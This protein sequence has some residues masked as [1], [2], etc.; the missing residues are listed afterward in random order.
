MEIDTNFQTPLW[1]VKYM[2]SL[3]PEGV[4]SVL[5]PTPGLGN[6]LRELEMKY[7]VTA[8]V[9]FWD[10]NDRFDA[11]VMN[12]PFTPMKMGYEILYKCMEMSDNIIALMPWLVMI[13]SEKRTKDIMHF[14]L[15][16]ITHLPQK[17][18]QGGQRIHSLGE[19]E[20]I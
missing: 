8:P 4:H 1:T 11:I 16:S 7:Q 10:V 18:F 14:G 2:T 19:L 20:Y 13:N 12:P 9:D 5:E 17:P 6:I 15:K 3:V